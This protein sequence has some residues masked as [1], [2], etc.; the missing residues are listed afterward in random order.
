LVNAVTPQAQIVS[1]LAVSIQPR[2]EQ[3]NANRTALRGF[4]PFVARIGG[5]TTD[6]AKNTKSYIAENNL[7]RVVLLGFT[8]TLVLVTCIMLVT[9]S[10]T[11]IAKLSMMAA[12]VG[13]ITMFM[14]WV[15]MALHFSLS[16]VLADFC[17]D[18][19]EFPLEGRVQERA[20]SQGLNYGGMDDICSCPGSNGW[21]FVNETYGFAL[22]LENDTMT[23]LKT[24]PQNSTEYV[25]LLNNIPLLQQIQA[26]C[27]YLRDCRWILPALQPLG[28]NMCGK[29]LEGAVAVW[30]T[31]FVIWLLMIPFVILGI[32]GFKRFPVFV[33]EGFF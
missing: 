13:F 27:V 15:T 19:V 28:K 23:Q 1:D 29:F 31:S 9:A 21:K 25:A 8:W 12:F 6:A 33:D 14:L 2:L 5:D 4:V 26:D 24:T 32:L 10:L 16:M 17:Y 11:N 7:W 20:D 3:I 18:I 30:A 22:E